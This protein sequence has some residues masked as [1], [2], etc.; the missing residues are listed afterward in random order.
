MPIAVQVARVLYEDASPADAVA[1]LMGREAKP[2]MH[3]IG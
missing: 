1:T 2:E 3:G